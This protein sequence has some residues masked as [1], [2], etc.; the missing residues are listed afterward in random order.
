MIFLPFHFTHHALVRNEEIIR[1][2][3]YALVCFGFGLVLLCQEKSMQTRQE[4]QHEGN[5]DND[6]GNGEGARPSREQTASSRASSPNGGLKRGAS[7]RSLN[8]NG[9]RSLAGSRGSS[10]GGR[11]SQVHSGRIDHFVQRGVCSV[12]PRFWFV[13]NRRTT[14]TQD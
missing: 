13:A 2:Q 10:R 6:D 4:D 3:F 5:D 7:Q 11:S 14:R 8:G 1:L 9:G 12:I